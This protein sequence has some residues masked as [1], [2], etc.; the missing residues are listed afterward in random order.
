MIAPS[1]RGDTRWTSAWP[2]A[3]IASSIGVFAA[4]AV[5]TLMVAMTAP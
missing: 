2:N 1:E 3:M 4:H 5:H